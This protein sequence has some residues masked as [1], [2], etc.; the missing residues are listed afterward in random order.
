MLVCVHSLHQIRQ[1]SDMKIKQTRTF[2]SAAR[3]E[4]DSDM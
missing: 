3:Q 4:M 2:V 1:R